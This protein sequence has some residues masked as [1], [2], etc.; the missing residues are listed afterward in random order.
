MWTDL[1]ADIQKSVDQG[2]L[3]LV[4]FDRTGA[5]S[6]VMPANESPAFAQGLV[7]G[8]LAERAREIVEG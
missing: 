3:V 8:L 1:A 2:E 7:N 6:R 5:F 4:L